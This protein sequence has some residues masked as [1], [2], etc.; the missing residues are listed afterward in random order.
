MEKKKI[1]AELKKVAWKIS[2]NWGAIW[3]NGRVGAPIMK[4][5]ELRI[6]VLA[7]W[8]LIPGYWAFAACF[9]LLHL[10]FPFWVLS[11]KR[12]EKRKQSKIV[13]ASCRYSKHYEL[14]PTTIMCVQL[15]SNLQQ[16]LRNWP[17][18]GVQLHALPAQTVICV[19]S[20]LS[21]HLL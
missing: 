9:P 15:R 12:V 8:N 19:P 18:D 11:N 14:I 4:G 1:S 5:V 17:A 20:Y 6:L 21:E 3:H 2:E 7:G 10:P 13:Q 16:Q